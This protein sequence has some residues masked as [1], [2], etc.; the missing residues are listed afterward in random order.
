MG[1]PLFSS[2]TATGTTATPPAKKD[3]GS[4]QEKN[5]KLTTKSLGSTKLYPVNNQQRSI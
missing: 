4:V 1:Q 5:S 3:E 2:M